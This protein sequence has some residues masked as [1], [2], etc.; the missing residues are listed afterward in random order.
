[1][2]GGQGSIGTQ[3]E[4]RGNIVAF[5]EAG[6]S[7]ALDVE[8]GAVV[9]DN[10]VYRWGN[11]SDP[12]PFPN[13]RY[14]ERWSGDVMVAKVFP[15]PIEAKGRTA[16]APAPARPDAPGET[17]AE[18]VLL[19]RSG[20]ERA[21]RA[22]FDAHVER[23]YH[24]CR[25]LLPHHADLDDVVQDVF[26]RAIES[27]SRLREAEAFS[28]WLRA[29][30]VHVVRN[31]IR[32]ER[33]LRR[34]GLRTHDDLPGDQLVDGLVARD[35]PPDVHAELRAVYRAMRRLNVDACAALVL[36]RVEGL[37]LPEIAQALGVSL[38]TA[39]RR[40]AAAERELVSELGLGTR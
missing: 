16:P 25:L 33:F 32:H 35:A 10:V 3:A 7:K 12:G 40:L 17:L 26:V 21:V 24:L 38:S 18:L 4:V 30:S 29:I 13:P 9:A 6:S 19:A 28:A 20:D 36:Q 14:A 37:T 8:D 2:F 34:I 23:V 31:R 11:Q 39:K 1:M 27:L 15:L 22:L 5:A